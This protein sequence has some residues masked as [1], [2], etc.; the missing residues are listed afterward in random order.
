LAQAE[1]FVADW[2]EM[3]ACIVKEHVKGELLAGHRP[4]Y[5]KETPIPFSLKTKGNKEEDELADAMDRTKLDS[6]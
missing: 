5:T 4:V 1:A 6:P 3:Y 2:V